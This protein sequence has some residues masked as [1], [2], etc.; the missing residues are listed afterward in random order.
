MKD[1]W[2]TSVAVAPMHAKPAFSSE[3][4]SQSLLWDT[5]D[6][7]EKKDNWNLIKTLDG[8][9]GWM[10]SFYM[11]ASNV[12]FN[13]EIIIFDRNM[14]VFS[15]K[16]DL[17]SLQ[18]VMSF[19]SKVPILNEHD[20]FLEI[21]FP[22]ETSG[23]IIDNQI[24]MKKNRRNIVSLSKNLLGVPYLWGGVSS[25]GYDC[26]GFVQSILK[27]LNISIA[28]DSSDQ[29]GDERL[30]GVD[31][32]DAKPGDLIF[33]FENEKVNHVG[34]I[35]DDYGIMH[36]SGEVKIESCDKNN[37]DYNKELFAKK[38]AAMSI[39]NLLENNVNLS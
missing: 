13:R 34:F 9:E 38:H 17:N 35:L 26:S 12:Y 4:V 25:F 28:R 30:C 22:D 24:K 23:F 2:V 27:A 11:H 32:K 20:D 1:R 16:N 31:F 8:Y 6:V 18:M 14:P 21:I 29:Y 36:C 39:E 7:L 33:F 5:I 37:D 3:M 10:H 15:R 19:G